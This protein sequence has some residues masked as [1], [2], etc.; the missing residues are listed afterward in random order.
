MLA[1]SAAG[2]KY[3]RAVQPSRK[4]LRGVVEIPEMIGWWGAGDG[5]RVDPRKHVGDVPVTDTDTSD[6][7]ALDGWGIHGAKLCSRKGGGGS[8]NHD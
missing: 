7:Q 5:A 6:C 1:A 8:T 2:R 4:S 3:K